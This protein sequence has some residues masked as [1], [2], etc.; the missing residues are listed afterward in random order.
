M[1]TVQYGVVGVGLMGIEHIRNLI[2]MD[3]TEVTCI[4]DNY[5]GSIVACEAM[6]KKEADNWADIQSFTNVSDMLS[7]RPSICDVVI[8]ATPNNT[9]YDVLMSAFK[10]APDDMNFLV[11]KPLCTTIEHCRIIIDAAKKRTG[12]TYVGLEYSYMPP[13]ARIIAD[14]KKGS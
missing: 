10:V 14:S 13:I 11:E 2:A 7:V 6:L 12:M 9:H 5:S 3:G 1:K 8:I 4:A